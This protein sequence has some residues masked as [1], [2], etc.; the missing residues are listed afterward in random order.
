MNHKLQS[1]DCGSAINL[2]PFVNLVENY[3][4]IKLNYQETNPEAIKQQFFENRRR[5]KNDPYNRDQTLNLKNNP[6]LVKQ[7]I[8]YSQQMMYDKPTNMDSHLYENSKQ[9][10]LQKMYGFL[11]YRKNSAE[12]LEKNLK[13]YFDNIFKT[14][15]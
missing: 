7:L 8:S 3:T 12:W 4:Q 2:D 11:D 10:S 15:K 9:E 1:F 6:G 14:R 13:E 5:L